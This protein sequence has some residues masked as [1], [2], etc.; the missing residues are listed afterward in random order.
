MIQSDR[1]LPS[2]KF[3]KGFR[4]QDSGFRIQD[5]GVRDSDFHNSMV[6]PDLDYKYAAVTKIFPMEEMK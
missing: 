5:S 1:S 6:N 2:V 4:I 3:E